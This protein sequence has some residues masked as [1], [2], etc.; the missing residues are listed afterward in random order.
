LD[1][2]RKQKN[3]VIYTEGKMIAVRKMRPGQGL[4][5]TTTEIPKIGSM[6]VLVKVKACSM[7]GTD[8]HIYNWDAPWNTR[9]KPPRT[10]GHELCGEIVEV[11][12]DVTSLQVGDYVSAESHIFDQTCT[13]CK[14]GNS[15]ICQNMKL[16]GVDVDGGFAEYVCLPERICWKNPKNM[17]PEIATLQESLGNSVFTVME[18]DV[19]GKT[20][21]IFG[22]GPTGQFAISVAKVMG[23]SKIM[24]IG[25]TE[26]HLNLAKRM[27]ADVIINRHSEDVVKRILEETNDLGADVFLE[28]SGSPIAIDQGLKSL[29]SE[30]TVVLLGLPPTD[31]TLNWSKDVV[32]K[33]AH[34]RGIWGRRIFQ[35]W[36]VMSGLLHSGKLDITPIITHKFKL[37]EIDKAIEVMKSGQSGKV[38]LYPK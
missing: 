28:M 3:E 21:S 27:G 10:L 5:F 23:A 6:D 12:K 24:A 18:G 1:T 30:G 32:L 15:H 17:P 37:E 22:L 8:V 33:C 19:A 26:F 20:V 9:V 36:Y 29:R 11:G 7:C 25:G 16:L 31:V 14:I 35:T 34:I 13:Q 2:I 4:D 38:V